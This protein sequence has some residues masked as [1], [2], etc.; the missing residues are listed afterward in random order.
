MIAVDE[1]QTPE[2]WAEEFETTGQKLRTFL[3]ARDP[4]VVIA[5][6]AMR[7]IME[8]GRP[9]EGSDGDGIEQGEVEFLQALFLTLDSAPK[10]APTSPGSF[11]RLWSTLSLHVASFLR[12]QPRDPEDGAAA[13]F[14]RRVRLQTIYYRN[15]FDRQSCERTMLDLLARFDV[16]SEAELGR[17]L[18]QTYR[19]LFRLSELIE[20]RFNRFVDQIRLLMTARDRAT[21]LRAIEFFCS[22]SPLARRAWRYAEHRFDRLQELMNA[23]YQISELANPWVF[24]L[25]RETLLAEFDPAFVAVIDRLSM[26][27]GDLSGSNP[28]HIYM[29]NPIWRRPFIVKPDGSLFV[30]LPQLVFSFP[31]Q[32]VE[33]LIEG[34]VR[35]EAS[36]AKARAG[37]LEDAIAAVLKEAMPSASIYQSVEWKDPATGT[38]YEND[39]VATL[40]NYIF[41]FEAKSGR[42]SDVA[43]RGGAKSLST[44]IKELFVEPGEQASRLQAYLDE[45]GTAARLW[46]KESE[47][48]V[49]LQLD[50]P[51]VV[52][53]F[54]VCIEHFAALTSA[55]AHL[56]E[57]GLVKDDTAW[58]PVLSLGELQMLSRF[59]D[60]EISFV[61]YLTR[62]STLEEVMDFDGDEQDLLSMYLINGLWLDPTELAGRKIMFHNADGAVRRSTTPRTERTAAEVLGIQLSP[63]WLSTVRELYGDRT[64][65]HRFDVITA[66][67]NQYPPAMAEFERKIRRWRRGGDGKDGDTLFAKYV[68]GTRQHVVAIHLAKRIGEEEWTTRARE[69]A[70][71]ATLSHEGPTECAVFLILRQS[72]ERTFDGIYFARATVKPS[73]LETGPEEVGTE[74]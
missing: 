10:L 32:I 38:R 24:T 64:Q 26:R 51:K 57:L 31:F 19:Q 55:K 17:P 70:R 50:R 1:V 65:R 34:N 58:A 59:L 74:G 22:I 52:H 47:T 33:T 20:E 46:L 45:H 73:A 68:I 27:P 5:K 41:V 6:T 30:P 29:N 21:A 48:P 23:G 25:P 7:K 53:K 18:S 42:I 49:D 72:K 2:H 63:F 13:F 9:H 69:I 40:G 39:V 8:G 71:F 60:T 56:K 16:V 3:L 62:R 28:D 66:I 36:Y 14:A 15:L 12:R 61:H 4:Y 37:Y 44:N 43:R 11:V 54:S 35:L 67:L